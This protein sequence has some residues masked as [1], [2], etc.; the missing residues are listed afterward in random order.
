[1]T[2][3]VSNL[4]C[5][6]GFAAKITTNWKCSFNC[7]ARKQLMHAVFSEIGSC[8]F[9]FSDLFSNNSKD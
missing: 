8:S 1:M 9:L 2:I 6:H 4:H 5:C 7:V 3:L